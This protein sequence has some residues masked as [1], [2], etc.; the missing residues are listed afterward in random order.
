MAAKIKKFWE[1]TGERNAHLGL[2]GNESFYLK[3]AEEMVVNH[4]PVKGKT[5][6]DFGCGGGFIGKTVLDHGA[7]K[8]IAYDVAARSIARAKETTKEHSGK[9]EFIL[10]TDHRWDFTSHKPDMII[11]L[12]VMIHFPTIG[13]MDN[14]LASCETSGAKYLVL[15]IRNKGRGNIGQSEPYS[16]ECFRPSPKTCLTLETSPAY[17]AR[18]MPSYELVEE[19]DATKAPPNCQVLWFKKRKVAE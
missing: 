6:I 9:T 10:L 11:A 5:I 1:N 14:F 4:F 12:A 19:T 7:R 15:E 13:Y 8:Y 17:V 2:S 3:R 18:K 16:A